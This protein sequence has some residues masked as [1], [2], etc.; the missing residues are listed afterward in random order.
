MDTLTPE[1]QQRYTR[2]IVL[3]GVGK[4]G[5]RRL[6][7]HKI[8]IIGTG[9]LGSPAATYLTAAGI[10]T[11]GLVDD[12]AV[13][14]SNLNRQTLHSTADIGVDKTRSAAQKLRNLNPD[15]QVI[16]HRLRV[17]EESIGPLLAPYDL[18]L[19]ATDNYPTRYIINDGCVRARKPL[20]HA[21]VSAFGGQAFLMLPGRTPCYRCLIPEAP[22]QPV[23]PPGLGAPILGATAGIMGTIQ[24]MESIKFI[25]GIGEPLIGKIL[26][27][28]G[29][30]MQFRQIPFPRDPECPV[31]GHLT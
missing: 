29:L 31:C 24:A 18:I 23:F 19:D 8:L 11:I 17:T 2:Q 13:E 27:F 9:G 20:M 26:T 4:E 1:Q 28:N 22:P 5:Q 14:L 21:G 6:L 12:D 30:T 25:L 10:G 16:E 15:V 7:R 3:E